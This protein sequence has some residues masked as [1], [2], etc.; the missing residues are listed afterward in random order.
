MKKCLIIFAKEPKKGQVK[1]RLK[2]ALSEGQ[3]LELYKAFLKD[4][5]MM[6]NKVDAD[7]RILAFEANHR[8]PEYLRKTF[9]GF[10]FYQQWG[11]DLGERMYHAF[12][13]AK[14]KKATKT[15]IIGS[16]TPTLPPQYIRVAFNCLDQDDM[17]LGPSRDGGYYLIGLKKN[18]KDLYENVRWS[19]TKVLRET[20][21]NAKRLR[22]K[23]FLL[24]PWYD[25]DEPKDLRRL[26]KE[27]MDKRNTK[28]VM[29]TRKIF[30][31]ISL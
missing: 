3:C 23:L 31:R 14:R 5:Y 16:D 4:I 9:R 20:I 21:R 27:L 12:N 18:H 28:S 30:K 8:K 25:I 11:K 24:K 19:S 15:I 13:F 1:T 7:L 22:K 26:Q 17:V 29:S 2:K 10:S 6:A